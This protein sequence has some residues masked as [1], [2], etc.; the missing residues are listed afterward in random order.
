MLR[1][2]PA[3]GALA[4][5][6]AAAMHFAGALKSTPALAALPF[7]L[8]ALAAL[9][10]L[11]LLP[12]L[13]AGGRWH[14]A[15]GL[16]LPLAA[17]GALW[18]WWGLTATWSPWNAGVAD[19]LPEILILGPAM[20]IAG[21]VVGGE[22]AARRVFLDA[23]ILLGL[24]VGGS[25]A[26]G[27]ATDAVVLGGQVGADPTR[28]RV[29]YQVAG[30]AIA[31]AAGLAAL[32]A[33][34]AR[35]WRRLLWL[36]TLAALGVAVLLPGGRT[37]FLALGLTVALAPA[38]RWVLQGC[39]GPALLWLAA[40]PLCGGVVL[41][42]LLLDPERAGELATLERLTRDT[43]G[44]DSARDILWAEAWR[45]GGFAGL[46]PGGFPVA[47][48]VGQDRG[49]HPHNH[50]IEALV[51][52]GAVG[53]ALWLAAFGGGALFMLSR[54]GRVEPDRAAAI[55]ALTLPLAM[56]AMVSTD[57]GNRMVWFALGLGLSLGVEARRV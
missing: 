37:A 26:W 45:W 50:A 38:L 1:A 49:L 31:C 23:V 21:L 27:I 24:F 12:L 56:T 34:G 9:G 16:G 55:L 11:A 3:L 10:L 25:V 5:L 8:T 39:M 28:V 41:A 52:G 18:A 29:Q 43:G 40:A 47:A 51:E 54:L 32:R 57:L 20:V 13:I 4:G 42:V 19:R 48:G 22:P 53:L 36:G 17:C 35:G 7:D 33:T 6:A 14:L 2:L 15:P 30:L 46:G 44:V